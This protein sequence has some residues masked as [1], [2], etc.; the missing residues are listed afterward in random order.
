ML[1]DL[2]PL[3]PDEN[4]LETSRVQIKRAHKESS[5]IICGTGTAFPR[6]KYTQAQVTELLGIENKTVQKLLTAKHIQ[7]RHLYLPMPPKGEKAIHD[8]SHE[9]LN[10]KFDNGILDIGVRAAKK[11]LTDSPFQKSE[12]DFCV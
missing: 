12:I 10:Q 11:A 2:A 4:D 8:E 7:T 5:A 1:K 9:E 6:Q 3:R